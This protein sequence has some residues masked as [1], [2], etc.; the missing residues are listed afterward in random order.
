MKETIKFAAIF[1]ND[2]C[3][4]L[5]KHHGECIQKSPFGTCKLGNIQGFWTSTNR[6]VD[7][8]EAYTLAK[9]SGQLL[10]KFCI[11]TDSV[12]LSEMLWDGASGGQHTYNEATGYERR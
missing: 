6:F 4:V 10:P 7:R 2:N 5:G 1:R 9:E 8:K 11:E 12:L 3:I